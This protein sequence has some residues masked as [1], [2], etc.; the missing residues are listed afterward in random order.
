MLARSRLACSLRARRIA[1]PRRLSKVGTT[2]RPASTTTK[3]EFVFGATSRRHPRPAC[4]SGPTLVRFWPGHHPAHAPANLIMS[5]RQAA[6]QG[7]GPAGTTT[8]SVQR[9]SLAGRGRAT[10][11]PGGPTPENTGRPRDTGAEAQGRG[12]RLAEDRSARKE[13]LDR[14]LSGCLDQLAEHRR[15][16]LAAVVTPRPLVD[17]ALKP[18]VRDG[19]MSARQPGFE[20]AEEAQSGTAEARLRPGLCRMGGSG[21]CC[22]DE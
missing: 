15:L 20:V 21:S 22:N 10:D 17:V 14:R 3:R 9:G 5:D 7:Q 8:A 11:E 6:R 2:A 1:T 18:L 16:G 4:P 19:V 13:V 12:R